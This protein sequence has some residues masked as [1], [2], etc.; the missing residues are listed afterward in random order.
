MLTFNGKE[1]NE[2]SEFAKKLLIMGTVEGGWDKALKM[3][4]DIE[5]AANKKLN[6]LAWCYLTLML[7]GDA[8]QEMDV[9]SDM[10]AY[11]V[12]LHLEKKYKPSDE[13][14]YEEVE[15]RNFEQGEMHTVYDQK[16]Q[17][18]QTIKGLRVQEENGCYCYIDLW[19]HDIEASQVEGEQDSDKLMVR[20]CN[21]KIIKKENQEVE[22]VKEFSVQSRDGN[23][24]E[25]D[26]LDLV[27]EDDHDN[28]LIESR[29]DYDT[30]DNVD[31]DVEKDDWHNQVKLTED[32]YLFE[33]E[34]SLKD[35]IWDDKECS[36]WK[37]ASLKNDNEEAENCLS[38]EGESLIND[39]EDDEKCV[40]EEEGILMEE[41][42]DGIYSIYFLGKETDSFTK[43][44][45][46][47]SKEK[48]D[49]Q[50][51]RKKL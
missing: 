8:L 51:E 45:I 34:E 35:D 9:I 18:E 48:E 44:I 29:Q 4:L 49:I 41:D 24:D 10:N 3:Q 36:I 42:A 6:K 38:G 16:I 47:K 25:P 7:A 22:K 12:W 31:A 50:M 14:A 19:E 30:L 40:I 37:E 15:R 26:S 17:L 11:A 27:F 39:F 13:K 20:N 2:W 5:V 23:K 21:Y 46:K 28:F 43:Q 32:E 33:E 1:K